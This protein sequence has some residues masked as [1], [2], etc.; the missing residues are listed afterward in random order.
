MIILPWVVFIGAVLFIFWRGY[1]AK[2]EYL[3]R[4]EAE[5]KEKARAEM[6]ERSLKTRSPVAEKPREGGISDAF[7]TTGQ[8][9]FKGYQA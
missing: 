8:G 3:R 4:R 2:K 9:N 6:Y 7:I 5:K 1:N